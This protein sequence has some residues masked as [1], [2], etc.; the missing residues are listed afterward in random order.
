MSSEFAELLMNDAIHSLG[1]FILA[2]SDFYRNGP[3]SHRINTPLFLYNLVPIV[4]LAST[5]RV[6]VGVCHTAEWASWDLRGTYPLLKTF[7][8]KR[9][10]ASRAFAH[11]H[12]S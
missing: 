12:S 10:A 4:D 2:D 3:R 11:Y 8:F 7:A 1:M 9:R 6:I 5:Q